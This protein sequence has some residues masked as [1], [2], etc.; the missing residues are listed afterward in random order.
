M[1]IRIYITPPCRQTD[2]HGDR[3]LLTEKEQNCFNVLES[4]VS[5]SQPSRP[6]LAAKENC[7]GLNPAGD[8]AWRQ[9]LAQPLSTLERGREEKK[10][11]SEA[12]GV[13]IRRERENNALL[14]QPCLNSPEQLCIPRSGE[15][16]FKLLLKSIMRVMT[17]PVTS[18]ISRS[19]IS[20]GFLD[21]HITE[22]RNAGKIE[23]KLR[24]P[25]EILLCFA[26]CYVCMFPRGFY[27]FQVQLSRFGPSQDIQSL[28]VSRALHF[29]TREVGT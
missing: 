28:C 4:D 15:K 16:R 19:R 11:K 2:Q 6:M 9:T 23:E 27:V 14:L 3:T 24:N 29:L 13:K 21:N 22:L 5:L 20:A 26:P 17:F 7:H 25:S 18:C 10:G 1:C 12:T 8:R